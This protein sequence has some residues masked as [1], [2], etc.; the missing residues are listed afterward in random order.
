M[1]VKRRASRWF[2]RSGIISTVDPAGGVDEK[3]CILGESACERMCAPVSQACLG[4]LTLCKAAGSI[5]RVVLDD[6]TRVDV[7]RNLHAMKLLGSASEVATWST[8][9]EVATFIIG[10]AALLVGA[11]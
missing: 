6:V 7:F 2:S 1:V 3:L 10:S 4:F 8:H 9:A 11:T 5:A